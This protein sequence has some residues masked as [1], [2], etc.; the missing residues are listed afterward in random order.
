MILREYLTD[1]SNRDVASIIMKYVGKYKP[2]HNHPDQHKTKISRRAY[3][4]VFNNKRISNDT[5]EYLDIHLSS[6]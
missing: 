5:L 6:L 2:P 1:C 4:R 3:T